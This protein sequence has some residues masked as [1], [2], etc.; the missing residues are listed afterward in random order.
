MEWKPAD[1]YQQGE[2]AHLLQK[3]WECAITLEVATGHPVPIVFYW[4]DKRTLKP[5]HLKVLYRRWKEGCKQA[6]VSER[7]PH[8]FR[9]TAVRNLE[10]AGVPLSGDE[11]HRP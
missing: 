1:L 8:D 7:I 5:I 3:Q 9:R 10:R 6:G 4:N 11:T 2:L